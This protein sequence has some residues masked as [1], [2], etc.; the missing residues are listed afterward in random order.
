[1]S[2]LPR[3]SPEN[4]ITVTRH[5]A[6]RDFDERPLWPGATPRKQAKVTDGTIGVAEAARAPRYRGER[7]AAS[8]KRRKV[9]GQ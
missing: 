9:G 3:I 5:C 4:P 1:M 6:K 7:R 2:N 8:R